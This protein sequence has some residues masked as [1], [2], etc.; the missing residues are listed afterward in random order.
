MGEHGEHLCASFYIYLSLCRS[1]VY[2]SLSPPLLL[3]LLVQLHTLVDLET[4]IISTGRVSNSGFAVLYAAAFVLTSA[5]GETITEEPLRPGDPD[6]MPQNRKRKKRSK[7]PLISLSSLIIVVI[8]AIYIG[9]RMY[10]RQRKR[11]HAH[12][13]QLNAGKHVMDVDHLGMGLAM[14]VGGEWIAPAD[15][16]VSIVVDVS[17]EEDDTFDPVAD[18]AEEQRKKKE[19]RRR[20]MQSPTNTN[21][22]MED[23]DASMS[24]NALIFV[25][26]KER[27]QVDPDM[28]SGI[29]LQADQLVEDWDGLAAANG[30]GEENDEAAEDHHSEGAEEEGV[31]DGEESEEEEEVYEYEY[32]EGE[33]EEEEVLV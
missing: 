10:R 14:G 30:E 20:A 13:V 21:T 29:D 11:H 25:N 1:E 18:L 9:W 16:N 8:I 32:E 26:M 15:Q 7:L 28:G 5:S 3:L 12:N 2:S 17:S 24:N 31:A 33:E 22:E 19:R 6:P 4:M 27:E 23:D